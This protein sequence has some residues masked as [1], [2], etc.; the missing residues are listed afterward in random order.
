[1]PFFRE[2]S[3]QARPRAILGILAVSVLIPACG[4]G[5][6][7]TLTPTVAPA[8]P[9]DLVA[10][11]GNQRVTLKWT[12][13]TAGLTFTVL[14][15]SNSGGPYFPISTPGGFT[16]PTTY[17]D[18][19]LTNDAR[20]FY[21]VTASNGFGSSAPSDEVMG[22]PAFA[23]TVISAGPGAHSL[24]VFPDGSV[25][26]WGQNDGGQLGNG[27]MSTVGQNPTEVI[28]INDVTSASAG[29]YHSMAL[30]NDG[31]VWGWGDNS[32]GQVGIDTG[33]A[34][35]LQPLQVPG[36]SNVSAISAGG[37]HSL[38]LRN[39]GTVWAWGA[40]WSGQVGAGPTSVTSPVQVPSLSGILAVGAGYDFSVALRNDGTVWTWGENG[41]GQL[42]NDSTMAS[43]PD[44]V[45]VANLNGVVAIGAGD[46][47]CLAVR[48]DGSVWSWGN[49]SYGQLGIGP[50]S[51]IPVRRPNR[52][53]NLSAVLAVSPR[54]YH[55]LALKRDGTAWSWGSNQG[56]GL[57]GAGS[58]D[59][60]NPTPAEIPGL[61]SVTSI[62][63]GGTHS[64]ARRSDGSVWTWGDNDLGQLGVGAAKK[65]DSPL[66][67]V[68]FT[69][70]AAISA[71]QFHVQIVRS[72][73]SLWV[74]GS[75]GSRQHGNK[76]TDVLDSP[77]EIPGFVAAVTATAAGALH[78]LALSNGTV[79][80][81]GLNDRGQ[82]GDDSGT[83]LAAPPAPVVGLTGTFIA[84]AAGVDHSLAVK[85][86]GTVWAWGDNTLG[87]LGTGS[88][89]PAWTAS[90]VQV[91]NLT[92]VKAVAAG[93]KFSLA[94]KN[95]GTVWAWGSASFG[96]LGEGSTVVQAAQSTPIQVAVVSNIDAIACGDTHSMA[97][98]NDG[99]LW[100]W[101]ENS[102]GQLGNGTPS[103]G[104][105]TPFQL[106]SPAGVTAIDGGHK[107]SLA[108]RTDGTVWAWGRNTSGQLGIGGFTTTS[109]PTQVVNM[110][111]ATAVTAG[112]AISFARK[113][114]GSLWGWGDNSGATLGNSLI[115]FT[116]TPILIPN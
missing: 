100:V 1:M 88:T 25:W 73:G 72:N 94:L 97:I 21:R 95:D 23:P 65:I 17:V 103:P 42:G 50:A 80:G 12:S 90:A 18:S 43:S 78:C 111:D 99:T 87:S 74:I 102:E 36:L 3:V 116:A 110:T 6:G 26:A 37:T 71:G 30:R 62:S 24:G 115:V 20:F 2:G 98:R 40:N 34:P 113:S 112:T 49:N 41:T 22:I 15:S 61:N 84:I 44:P 7:G 67:T 104:V 68:N 19:G 109:V 76:T 48:D 75:N 47:H 16:A 27:S 70:A 56:M 57:L 55:S 38:A 52:V 91:L 8:I 53:L 92:D 4:T 86:D 82:A 45:Q 59:G 10:L 31:T 101:G 54:G 77:I 58:Q 5:G 64:L 89:S 96:K 107:Y 63:A 9:A 32:D 66:R 28:G 79:F 46:M 105:N 33:F 39:D 83:P 85:D 60:V 29:G 35:V 81:W 11:T 93:E 108:V 13:P 69:E 14:R 106:S 51:G 114:D